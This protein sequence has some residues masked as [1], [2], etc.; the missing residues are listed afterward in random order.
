[1]SA[2][3]H[4]L[5]LRW[6]EKARHDLYV[7]DKML[8]DE[9]S[10]TDVIGFH[11]QQAIEKS[12]K[13]LLTALG[14]KFPRTHDLEELIDMADPLLPQLSDHRETC[15]VITHFAVAVRYPDSMDEPMREDVEN[16]AGDAWAI[17]R[18]IEKTI[19]E[20]DNSC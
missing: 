3:Q 5:A 11:S 20:Q 4:E 2:K 14:A 6:I 12:L 9:E 17:F 19:R 1:M 10:P 13:A 7:V 18:L 15:A 16:A 8:D